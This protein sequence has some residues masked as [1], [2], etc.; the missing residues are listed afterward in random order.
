MYKIAE[1]ESLEWIEYNIENG[2]Q[3]RESKEDIDL[4]LEAFLLIKLY[5]SYKFKCRNHHL[6]MIT[7]PVC[8]R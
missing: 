8:K 7:I 6:L 5:I 3:F 4:V 1:R 2:I